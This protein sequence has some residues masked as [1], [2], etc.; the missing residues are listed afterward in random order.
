MAVSLPKLFVD[1]PTE[2]STSLD[3]IRWAEALTIP[4]SKYHVH[5]GIGLGVLVAFFTFTRKIPAT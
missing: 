4:S 2:A 3:D 1:F 5:S